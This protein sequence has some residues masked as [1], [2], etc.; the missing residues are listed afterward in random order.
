MHDLPLVVRHERLRLSGHGC[1]VRHHHHE[2]ILMVCFSVVTKNICICF[3]RNNHVLV[4][5]KHDNIVF[6]RCIWIKLSGWSE[7]DW[8]IRFNNE[9]RIVR[10]DCI[11]CGCGF[12]IWVHILL[13][14]VKPVCTPIYHI[15]VCHWISIA[16]CN[17]RIWLN[18]GIVMNQIVGTVIK[19]CQVSSVW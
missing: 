17:P 15:S 2:K 12:S 9:S 19:A 6:R 3:V 11:Y 16:D 10:V 5:I 13:E 14:A 4:F 8:I 7:V 18:I 1:P